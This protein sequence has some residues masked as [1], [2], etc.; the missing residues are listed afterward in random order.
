MYYRVYNCKE[1]LEVDI[2]GWSGYPALS[3]ICYGVIQCSKR[4]LGSVPS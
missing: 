3:D 1:K 2:L 4:R